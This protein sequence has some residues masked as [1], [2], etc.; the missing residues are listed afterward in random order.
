VTD[1]RLYTTGL[2]GVVSGEPVTLNSQQ[3]TYE[4]GLNRPGK[5]QFTVLKSDSLTGT[6]FGHSYPNSSAALEATNHILWVEREGVLV[7]AGIIWE[8]GSSSQ[9][10][11]VDIQ[12]EEVASYYSHFRLTS[13]LTTPANALALLGSLL[14]TVT[15]PGANLMVLE[16]RPVSTYVGA[17]YFPVWYEYDNRFLMDLFTELSRVGMN[18]VS[19]GALPTLQSQGF[20]WFQELKYQPT[21][22]GMT[23]P[24]LVVSSP[25][26]GSD[27]QGSVEFGE[28]TA[29]NCLRLNWTRS[30]RR[31]VNRLKVVGYGQRSQAQRWTED[32][33]AGSFYPVLDGVVDDPDLKLNTQVQSLARDL[34]TRTRYPTFSVSAEILVEPYSWAWGT[35]KVGDRV[36][37]NI[38][39]AGFA[40]QD[41]L[42]VSS[43]SYQVTGAVETVQVGLT[44]DLPA[45]NT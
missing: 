25:R 34:V 9:S 10:N 44:P 16:R 40:M 11:S 18:T 26:A 36:V 32:L 38:N 17:P 4:F 15:G 24:T 35:W 45:G 14:L 37:A 8:A 3:F 1:Y 41:K 13:S 42:R 30:G 22:G 27:A 6:F 33:S 5:G 20:E 2:G 43:L 21:K 29:N 28:G 12:A 23:W 19:V 7:W 39:D 31:T